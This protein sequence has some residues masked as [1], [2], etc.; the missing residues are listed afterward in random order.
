MRIGGKTASFL[1]SP[2]L[3]PLPQGA[4]RR[5]ERSR[6]DARQRVPTPKRIRSGRAVRV[7]FI[8][9]RERVVVFV[10]GCFWHGCAV[11][12]SPGRWLKRSSMLSDG[13]SRRGAKAQRGT[14]AEE[15]RR[16]L[17]L[18]LSRARERGASRAR[19]GKLFWTGK[20]AGNVARDRF[21]NRALRGAGWKVIR[22]W[23]HELPPSPRLRRT[24]ASGSSQKSEDRR[25]EIRRALGK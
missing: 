15:R 9:R 6:M 21:V 13:I 5:G 8:F 17:T 10:D 25:Q 16:T 18:T 14:G 3:N 20:M 22:I 24:G 2:H 1:Q 12:S 7:D 23:E 4:R 11:H 19:T